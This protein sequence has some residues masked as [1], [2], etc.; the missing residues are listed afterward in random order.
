[1]SERGTRQAVVRAIPRIVES[2]SASGV[3]GVQWFLAF[4]GEPVIWLVTATDADKSRVAEQG[5]FRDIVCRLLVEAGLPDVLAS[6]VG[7]TVESEET[8][9]RDFESNWF[10]AM[11]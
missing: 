11:R 4:Q 2:L 6:R 10:Y 7:V 1:M 3:T 9:A 8:V 5:F